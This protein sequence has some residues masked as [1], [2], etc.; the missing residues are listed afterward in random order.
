MV[1]RIARWLRFLGATS[2]A[3]TSS[4]LKDDGELL[5]APGQGNLLDGDLAVHVNLDPCN[6]NLE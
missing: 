3:L 5:F 6:D 4:L 2:K 1:A